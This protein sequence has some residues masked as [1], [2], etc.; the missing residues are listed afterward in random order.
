MERRE[1]SVRTTLEDKHTELAKNYGYW[2]LGIWEK[3]AVW[4]ERRSVEGLEF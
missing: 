2:V 3:R 4:R 1:E